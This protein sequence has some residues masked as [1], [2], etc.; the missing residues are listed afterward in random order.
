MQYFLLLDA[1]KNC[2][3]FYKLIIRS[4]IEF[5]IRNK[6]PTNFKLQKDD[7]QIDT[8]W[9]QQSFLHEIQKNIIDLYICS[10][11]NIVLK[12]FLPTR[13]PACSHSKWGRL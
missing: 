4:A 9:M 7:V 5:C 13:F 8:K 6:G 11:K 12:H 1:H 3:T 2:V 10:E